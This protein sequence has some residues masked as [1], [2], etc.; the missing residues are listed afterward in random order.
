MPTEGIEWKPHAEILSF[1]EITRLA[2][3]FVDLGTRKIR[4]TGGEPLVRR[5]V[6]SLIAMLAEIPG[7]ELAMTT[8]ASKL[9][10][11]AGALRAAG[12]QRINVSLDSLRRDRF[13]SIARYDGLPRVLDGLQAAKAAGLDPIKVNC[14]V[15]RGVNDDELVDFANF[16]RETGFHVRFIEFMPLDGEA[17]WNKSQVVSLEEIVETISARYRIHSTGK[18]SGPAEIF[19]FE[20]RAAGSV[21]VIA[22]VTRPFCA[23]CNRIRLTA[24]GQMLA[25]LFALEETDLR[26]LIRSG[27]DDDEIAS[28]ITSTVA[29]KWKGHA[30]GDQSFVRPSR[31]MSMLG[32]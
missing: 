30:I 19:E 11:K 16:A 24:E 3:I 1:E 23:N 32:G 6:E 9:R 2:R 4:I 5:D 17:A 22:S 7:L 20:D 29:S 28:A 8:N 26:H 18:M 25:C 15:M 12:L 10:E 31:S 13:R 14:V 21:G 27:A